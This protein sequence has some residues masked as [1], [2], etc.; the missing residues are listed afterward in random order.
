MSHFQ[1]MRHS[2]PD[3]IAPGRLK[4]SKKND[5]LPGA[6]ETSPYNY[7]FE[8][9]GYGKHCRVVLYGNA[10][11]Q[12]FYLDSSRHTFKSSQVEAFVEWFVFNRT[13]ASPYCQLDIPT[14]A[15]T[16]S[17]SSQTSNRNTVMC[18]A[19]EPGV[20]VPVSGFGGFQVDNNNALQLPWRVVLKDLAGKPI[21]DLGTDG[22]SASIVLMERE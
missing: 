13:G 16:Y 3:P 19:A 14:L 12:T 8:R 5:M 11:D 18:V 21:T 9:P 17:Y 22:W 20:N 2:T 10:A 6:F 4:N 1:G 7:R 15:G